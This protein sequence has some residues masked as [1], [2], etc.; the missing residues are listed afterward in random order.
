[1]M[2]LLGAVGF[3]LLIACANVANLVLVKTLARQKEIAIRTA[4]GASS[5]RVLRQIL[6]ETLMLSLCGG[7]LGLV[8]AH[9]GV[10]LIVAFLAQRLPFAANISLD[11]PVLG[12]TLLVSLLTG[13]IAGVVPAFRAT[14]TNL[15]ESLKAGV[16]RTDADSGG[17]RTRSVLVVSEMALSLVLLIGAGLMIRSLSRLRSLDPGFDSH[18]V[19]TVSIALSP[20]KYEKPVQQAAFYDQVLQ[21]VRSVPG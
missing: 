3:V 11:L 6:A 16:G 21:R 12:F 9:F 7:V 20:T 17:N 5:A 18:N 19:L 13:V 1:L 10:R 2:I 4:L 15:N 8:I 14:K